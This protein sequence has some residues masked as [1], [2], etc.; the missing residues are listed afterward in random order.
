MGLDWANQPRAFKDYPGLPRVTLPR[1]AALPLVSPWRAF[2]GRDN[3]ADVDFQAL[4]AVLFHAAGLTR[5]AAHKGGE[6]FYRAS[7]SAGA[8]YPC[9]VYLAWPGSE[10]LPAGLYHYD[11]SRHALARLRDGFPGPDSLG[12]PERSRLPKE[13][14]LLVTAIFFRSAWKYRARAYRYLNLDAGHVAEGLALGLSAHGV[15]HAVEPDFDDDAVNAF[16]GI[17]PGREGCLAAVRFASGPSGQPP[18]PGRLPDAAEGLSRMAESDPVPAEV[19]A[20]HAACSN[21]PRGGRGVSGPARSG[22]GERLGWRDLPAGQG[23]KE[24]LGLFE[25]MQNRKSRRAFV[26]IPTER[27]VLAKVAAA[28]LPPLYP[29]REH[30]CENACTVGLVTGA[31]S[32]AGAGFSLLDR[33]GGRFGRFRDGDMRQAMA[34]ACLDQLWLRNAALQ[35]VFMIDFDSFDTALGDRGYRAALLDAGRLGHRLYLAAES[36][37]L[38]ACGVGAFYDEEASELL[39]LPGGTGLAYVVAVGPS[40]G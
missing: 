15:R 18:A 39:G 5:S 31:Q 25:A 35:A 9:E 19:L 38:G 1:D 7:P 14:I 34:A 29:G 28:L 11:V 40:K 8:L 6:F 23:V 2:E 10:G 20:V 12:L 32:F 27:G 30:P 13:A 21:A 4:S 24:E 16:L 33:Q 26:S 36:L 22:L 3:V 17:D 37:G